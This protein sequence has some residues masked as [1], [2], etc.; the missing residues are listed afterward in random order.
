MNFERIVI[1]A[2]MLCLVAPAAMAQDT[3]VG[4]GDLH[5]TQSTA[6]STPELRLEQQG[7]GDASMEFNQSNLSILYS[8]GIDAADSNYK[9]TN[10]GTLTSGLGSIHGDGITLMQARANGIVDFNNQS[11]AR[12][13]LNHVQLVPFN[14]W[15]PVEF[16]DDSTLFVGYDQQGEFTLW[17]PTP[18]P[19]FFMPL[20]EGF[21]QIHARTAFEYFPETPIPG[22]VS[23]AVFVNG[24]MYS[25]GNNLQMVTGSLDLL[26]F[27]NA[28]NVSDVMWLK[29]G[30]V[31]EVYVLQTVEPSP[32]NVSLVFGP[33]Q[34]YV[35]IHK[36]S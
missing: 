20:T 14:V 21:Y 25:Q 29:P 2:A 13:S 34:T 35:A 26:L 7:A 8:T 28:P 9:T 3:A 11:R 30:D 10:T 16:D 5:I 24:T 31:V 15:T 19:A 32:G 17:T 12:A 1:V 6:S 22:Y 18:T 36:D 27:N 23:I 4:N 33:S